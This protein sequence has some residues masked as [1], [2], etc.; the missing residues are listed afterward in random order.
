MFNQ[1]GPDM[2]VVGG[3]FRDPCRC[4]RSLFMRVPVAH[5]AGGEITEGAM[6]EAI[7]HAVTKM[8]HLHFPAAEKYRQRILQLGEQPAM[9]H[10][11]GALALDNI[12][13][14]DLLDRPTL[15][16]AIGLT[17]EVPYFLVTYHP[18][19]SSN[20]HQRA[21]TQSLKRLNSSVTIG[22]SLQAS[23]RIRATMPSQGRLTTIAERQQHRTIVTISLGPTRYLSAMSHA[24]A[25]I[26]NSSSG[27]VE[28]P[29]M[30]IPTV[31]TG[32]RQRGRLREGLLSI[33]KKIRTKSPRQYVRQTLVRSVLSAKKLIIPL[34]GE[35]QQGGF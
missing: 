3:P 7:R 10:T 9:V 19:T 24:A 34:D 35:A 31:N 4:I 16:K 6:D 11:V 26:G 8:A 29:A 23:M 33:V 18:V 5:I 17:P 21:L 32:D 28:A 27:I 2:L 25:V 14:L 15:S 12:E 30:G 22:L 20:L 1:M 13:R